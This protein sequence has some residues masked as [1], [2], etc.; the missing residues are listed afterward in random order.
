[1][2]NEAAKNC[3]AFRANNVD[4]VKIDDALGALSGPFDAIISFNVFQHIPSARGYKIINSLLGMAS[5]GAYI[6]LHVCLRRPL[7]PLSRVINSIQHRIPFA[8]YFRNVLK[9]RSPTAPL[10]QMNEYDFP[11]VLS[12][13]SK[14]GLTDVLVTLDMQNEIMTAALSGRKPTS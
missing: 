9:G 14:R 4:L 8:N 3:A 12:I 7:T 10:M 6:M 1:M 13:F 11:T 5:P 2:L